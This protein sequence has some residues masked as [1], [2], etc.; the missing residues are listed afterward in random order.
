MGADIRGS[1]PAVPL[2]DS[3]CPQHC[4][5]VPRHTQASDGPVGKENCEAQ[6]FALVQLVNSLCGSS[7]VDG[8]V[9][10]KSLSQEDVFRAICPGSTHRRVHKSEVCY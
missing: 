5:M 8:G 10:V 7:R 1:G 9:G 4:V 6:Q 3:V 2:R